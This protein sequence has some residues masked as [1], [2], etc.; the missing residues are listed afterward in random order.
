MG[1]IAAVT[2]E[3]VAT[4]AEQL[5]AE[6]ATPTAKLLRSRLGNAGSLG[7]YQTHLAQWRSKQGNI[8]PVTRTLPPDVQ[9][10][11]FKFLDE[12]VSRSIDELAQQ[13]EQARHEIEDLAADNDQQTSL[14]SQLQAELAAQAAG[15]ARQEGQLSLL[16]EELR[17]AR[18]ETSMERREAEAAKLVPI[19]T[20]TDTPISFAMSAIRPRA[21]IIF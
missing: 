20:S 10:A 3:Q 16:Q 9:R 21:S 5:H 2:Y 15:M 4:A 19:S 6:G 18:E 11:V 13:L 7:T 17:S 14:A 12:E 1:R 8:Q